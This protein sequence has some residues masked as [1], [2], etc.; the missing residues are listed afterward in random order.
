MRSRRRDEK[1]MRGEYY[2]V[3]KIGRLVLRVDHCRNKTLCHHTM[4]T[5]G[6]FRLSKASAL[7]LVLNIV[8]TKCS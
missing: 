3:G 4:E 1:W 8:L 7:P 6:K 2:K 5:K